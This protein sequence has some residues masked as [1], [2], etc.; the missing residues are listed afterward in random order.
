[1][2]LPRTTTLQVLTAHAAFTAGTNTA[3]SR[4]ASADCPRPIAQ[5]GSVAWLIPNLARES[6]QDD[7]RAV[8]RRSIRFITMDKAQKLE[9]KAR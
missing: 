6:E 2:G 9:V 1:M 8:S 4:Q 7:P 5:I 3:P